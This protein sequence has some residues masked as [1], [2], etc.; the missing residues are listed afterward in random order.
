MSPRIGPAVSTGLGGYV[1]TT[2]V[3]IDIELITAAY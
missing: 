1:L 2:A 3:A